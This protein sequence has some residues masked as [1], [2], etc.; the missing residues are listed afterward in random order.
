MIEPTTYYKV[1]RNILGSLMSVEN[2]S[3]YAVTYL[4]GEFVEASIGRIFVFE[5]LADAVDFAGTD[6]DLEVWECHCEDPLKCLSVLQWYQQHAEESSQYLRE[7]QVFWRDE[8]FRKPANH[9]SHKL[10]TVKALYSTFA[11]EK[12]KL[13]ELVP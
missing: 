5:N 3:P 6:P 12:V 10:G 7:L 1:V 4:Q 8:M 2:D 11:A 9:A 13:V